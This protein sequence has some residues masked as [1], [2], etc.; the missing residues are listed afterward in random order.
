MNTRHLRIV[1]RVQGVGFRES[2]RQQAER[3]GITGWVRNCMDGTVEAVV[4][5]DEAAVSAMLDWCRR[6][7]PLARVEA[8]E[9]TVAPGEF[10]DFTIEPSE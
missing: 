8:V 3:L 7:P 5:G 2:M 1:G 9:Q 4:S 10:R 6:G